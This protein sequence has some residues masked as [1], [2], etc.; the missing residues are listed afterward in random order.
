MSTRAGTPPPF[1][2][3]FATGIGLILFN[4]IVTAR[5]RAIVQ[6]N[7]KSLQGFLLISS[8][9]LTE[10]T[11]HQSVVL[12]VQHNEQGALGLI[13]NRPSET[14][15]DMVW[16]QIS[17]APCL[18]DEP[19]HEGGPCPCDG[20]PMVLHGDPSLSQLEVIP[21]VYFSHEKESV[22]QLVGGDEDERPVKFFDGYAGWGA[23]QLEA[24]LEAGAWLTVPGEPE[25][26]FEETRDLWNVLRRRI[27]LRSAYPWL[28]P[29]MIPDD[30]SLN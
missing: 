23:G 4:D 18:C 1:S 8:P 20:T 5:L 16:D 27:T 10:P 25:H 29:E 9:M 12:I 26:V 17:E 15:I 30:P 6:G 24:E 28:R 21:G 19:L 2:R 14:T 22:E 3:C 7:M 13:L 11:F